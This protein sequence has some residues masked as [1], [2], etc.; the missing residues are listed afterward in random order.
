M[1]AKEDPEQHG[2]SPDRHAKFAPKRC[3]IW[4][5]VLRDA[6]SDR[7]TAWSP[8]SAT[9]GD[10]EVVER[11][12][13]HLLS[14]SHNLLGFPEERWRDV[15]AGRVG[16][17]A[18]NG[19]TYDTPAAWPL[20]WR[21]PEFAQVLF[22]TRKKRRGCPGRDLVSSWVEA[23]FD[24]MTYDPGP[25]VSLWV[26]WRPPVPRSR[27]AAGPRRSSGP[28]EPRAGPGSVPGLVEEVIRWV[29]SAHLLRGG[30]D[31]Q[32]SVR[33]GSMRATGSVLVYLGEP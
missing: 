31:G 14:G 6:I 21:S 13:A 19:A 8:T 23:D 10:F 32:S 1:I 18:S 4:R 24:D 5:R 11:S 29:T 33:S 7:S 17:C 3:A 26:A 2:P 12:A 27:A 25:P 20:S 16:S 28:W 22:T 15:K 9:D 30:R